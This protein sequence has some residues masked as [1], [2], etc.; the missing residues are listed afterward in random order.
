[1][2]LAAIAA[3]VSAAVNAAQLGYQIS[4]APGTPKVS[5]TPKPLTPAQNQ[6]QTMQ[7]SQAAPNM[8]EATGGS[9]SPEATASYIAQQSNASG[10]PLAGQNIQAAINQFFGLTG[11]GNQGLA[12]ERSATTNPI[13]DLF[14]GA[15][16][17]TSGSTNL[18]GF[19]S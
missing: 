9:L 17:M 12:P 2:P 1:M 6:Q 18:Q 13:T 19:A 3:I 16:P 7:A 4:N 11:Q 15:T 8:Q 10:V 5:T 14:T